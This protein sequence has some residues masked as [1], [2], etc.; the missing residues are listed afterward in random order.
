M[1]VLVIQSTN[2]KCKRTVKLF[3]DYAVISKPQGDILIDVEAI[4]LL[5]EWGISIFG[6]R[7]VF[8]QGHPKGK[9]KIKL[10]SRTLMGNP[11]ARV[12][13]HINHN[14]LDNRK[15]NLR[16]CTPSEN[17][18]NCRGSSVRKGKYKGV[19]PN[20]HNE[21][22]KDRRR[23]TWW[24]TIT[25]KKQKFYLGSFKTEKEA[26]S[27]YNVAAKRLFGEFAYLNS[28]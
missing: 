13:D 8:L 20:S 23:R 24:A 25:H 28:I 4:P 16:V 2:L 26:A 10:L 19:Y 12:V 6:E 11:K 5:R 22:A 21:N 18:Y 1:K 9:W 3:K 27:A 14:T 17:A 15:K 7:R